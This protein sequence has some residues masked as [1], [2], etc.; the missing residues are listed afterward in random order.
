[1]LILFRHAFSLNIQQQRAHHHRPKNPNM[2]TCH[3]L[4]TNEP[5]SEIAYWEKRGLHLHGSVASGEASSSA[6]T[7][8]ENLRSM[9]RWPVASPPAAIGQIA[10]I[11]RSP[12]TIVALSS[13]HDVVFA[14][15]IRPVPQMVYV[16][17]SFRTTMRH[18]FTRSRWEAYTQR[19]L[20]SLPAMAVAVGCVITASKPH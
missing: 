9:Y 20:D 16:A 18:L 7:F 10:F 12:N 2:G 8:K 6:H 3:M 1:M 11:A 13:T 5:K 4:G 19:A 17:A 15:Q 14:Q